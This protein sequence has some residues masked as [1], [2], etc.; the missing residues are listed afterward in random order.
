MAAS[1]ESLFVMVPF[2]PCVLVSSSLLRNNITHSPRTGPRG[3]ITDIGSDGS[4]FIRSTKKLRAA[5]GHTYKPT[6]YANSQME[7]ASEVLCGFLWAH[8]A[9]ML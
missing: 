4:A 3:G 5:S 9:C 7:P 6:I 8:H 2:F 1:P